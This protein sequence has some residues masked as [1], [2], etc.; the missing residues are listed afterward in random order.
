[1]FGK[2]SF[3]K[4][5]L[6]CTA[7]AAVPLGIASAVAAA[8][9]YTLTGLTIAPG[10][11]SSATGININGEVVG[12][13]V[14][15]SG[16][17]YAT[18]YN[19]GAVRSLATSGGGGSYFAAAVNDSGQIAGQSD[20]ARNLIQA[21][22]W[23]SSGVTDLGTLGGTNSWAAG[24]NNSGQVVGAAETNNIHGFFYAFLWTAS[25]GM[26]NLG[27]LGGSGGGS[28][29]TAIN[30]VG[31]VVGGAAPA[32][33]S[34]YPHAFL[35]TSAGGMQDLGTFGGDS[36]YAYSINTSGEVVGE[37]ATAT[38][39]NSNAFLWVKGGTGG[40]AGNPQMQDL[41]TLGGSFSAA[42]GINDHGAVVGGSMVSAAG[43][44]QHAFI[45]TSSGGMQDLNA[46]IPSGTG[47]TLTVASGINADG[48]IVGYG[49]NPSGGTE[50]FLLTPVPEPTALALF[51]LGFAG[52]SLKRR[53][54]SENRPAA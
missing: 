42:Y 37:A 25:A 27:G 34:P 12:D 15:A 4:S 24:I 22:L 47:W 2:I 20:I 23:T 51:A 30:S 46:L 48:D 8:P 39:Q 38:D 54:R 31:E 11:A 53:K 7:L 52:L 40:P 28:Y 1:M 41:G 6:F 9:A 10:D 16:Y 43:S 33:T 29:G 3:N 13:A 14:S 19:G 49:T 45:W 5:V 21:L 50:A 44:A 18:S 32:G 26:Q 17:Q 35:W 36:S